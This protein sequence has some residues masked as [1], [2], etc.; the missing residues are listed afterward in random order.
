[1]HNGVWRSKGRQWQVQMVLETLWLDQQNFTLMGH[2]KNP[3]ICGKKY[4]SAH[5][6]SSKF[7][8]WVENC[9]LMQ[10]LN[11]SRCI[12]KE[13]GTAGLVAHK[14][15]KLAVQIFSLVIALGAEITILWSLGLSGAHKIDTKTKILEEQTSTCSENS[16]KLFCG[17]FAGGKRNLWMLRDFQESTS[18]SKKQLIPSKDKGSRQSKRFSWLNYKL[19]GL[20]RTKRETYQKCQNRWRTTGKPKIISKVCRDTVTK[21]RDWLKHVLTRDVKNDKKLFNDKQKEK[22]NTVFLLNRRGKSVTKNAEKGEVLRGSFCLH[23]HWC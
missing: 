17:S 7:L 20:I 9:F 23:Q 6:K 5:M 3:D 15:R 19:L 1:M 14:P 11:A 13:W 4:T 21:A 12:K 18:G 2:F 10:M 22:E 8:E 16:W